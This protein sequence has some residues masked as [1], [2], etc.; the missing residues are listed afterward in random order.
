MGGLLL[1]YSGVKGT[2]PRLGHLDLK[3]SVERE[4]GSFR[5]PNSLGACSLPSQSTLRSSF[6]ISGLLPVIHFTSAAPLD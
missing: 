4:V 3:P 6:G 5:A 1:L 2:V